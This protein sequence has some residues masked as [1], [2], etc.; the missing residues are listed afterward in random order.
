MLEVLSVSNTSDF[1][2]R[3]ILKLF[4][5][6]S[7][8]SHYISVYLS[9]MSWYFIILIQFVQAKYIL[10]FVLIDTDYY[11][12]TYLFVLD[13]SFCQRFPWLH[14][15]HIEPQPVQNHIY[16]FISCIIKGLCINLWSY[17]YICIIYSIY[18]AL[19]VIINSLPFAFFCDADEFSCIQPVC[20]SH[21]RTSH[22]KQSCMKLERIYII[23]P[24]I[25][26]WVLPG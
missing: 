4:Q 26:A 6:F 18:Q 7:K 8:S 24:F 12:T 9:N 2:T 14:S 3:S 17:L 5:K 16:S 23:I 13:S 20:M 21:A 22:M 1:T 25:L 10:I 11:N 19:R 15:S